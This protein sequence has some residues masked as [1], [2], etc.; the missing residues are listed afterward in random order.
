MNS[1]AFNGSNGGF[2]LTG[3]PLFYSQPTFTVSLQ[4]PIS[5]KGFIVYAFDTQNQRIGS[6]T[7]ASSKS[8]NVGGC[9]ATIGHTILINSASLEI[10]TWTLS[11]INQYD[12]IKFVGAVVVDYSTYF[13]LEPFITRK[14]LTTSPTTIKQDTTYGTSG[15]QSGDLLSTAQIT[16]GKSAISGNEITSNAITS[17]K[18]ANSGNEITTTKQDTTVNPVT[19]NYATGQDTT[20][21]SVTGKET[22][23][24]QSGD[25]LSTAQITSG[26]SAN[27]GNEIT[28]NAI[29]SG[30]SEI[31]GNN[32]STTKITSASQPNN[33]ITSSKI[34]SGIQNGN[35]ETTGDK[36]PDESSVD[37]I[38]CSFAF[39]ISLAAIAFF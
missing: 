20:V 16:S 13:N 38:R 5:F 14:A 34:T 11:G 23:G 18:S 31:S 27:S 17:G 6:W 36:N 24:P 33:L 25:L 29:T 22:T 4:G 8:A 3:I 2:I 39:I 19:G 12:A 7:A 21:N 10:G 1:V 26:K 32:L 9:E 15:P 37:V 28:S 30:K 35:L